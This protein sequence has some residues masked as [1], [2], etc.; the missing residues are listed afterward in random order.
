MSQT[1]LCYDCKHRDGIPGGAHSR[2]RHPAVDDTSPLGELVALM[3]KRAGAYFDES[4]PLGVTGNPHGIRQGWFNWP[5]N[6]DPIWLESC[7]GFQKDESPNR[8]EPND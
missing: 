6:F 7:N 8:R 2:C 1:P 5:F 3:G 4:N